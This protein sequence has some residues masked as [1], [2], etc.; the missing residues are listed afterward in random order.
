VKTLDLE[1]VA[2]LADMCHIACT[3]KELELLLEAIGAKIEAIQPITE[4]I[5]QQVEPC[6]IAA[7][8]AN[9]AMRSDDVVSD[10]H[11]R[12]LFLANLPEAEG[13]LAIIP[14]ICLGE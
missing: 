5:A 6:Y 14:P 2:Q 4:V 10:P 11:F 8:I 1:A 7:A 9:C 13:D 12:E 3:D